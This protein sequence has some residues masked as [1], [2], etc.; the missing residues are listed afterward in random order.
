MVKS[1]LQDYFTEWPMK[2]SYWTN[3]LNRV[4]LD[5]YK[6]K[7]PLVSEIRSDAPAENTNLP[8]QLVL[9]YLRTDIYQ[10]HGSVLP[11]KRM[12]LYEAISRFKPLKERLLYILF[13]Q[14]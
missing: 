14:L 5:L 6:F 9:T 13:P 8:I 7:M 12:S 10:L 11:S 1:L 3:I 2:L 4:P